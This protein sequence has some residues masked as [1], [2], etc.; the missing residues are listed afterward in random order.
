MKGVRKNTEKKQTQRAADSDVHHGL[1]DALTCYMLADVGRNAEEVWIQSVDEEWIKAL[2][3]SSHYLKT[4]KLD[5]YDRRN[6]FPDASLIAPDHPVHLFVS[7]K[8]VLQVYNMVWKDSN[9]RQ[10]FQSRICEGENDVEKVRKNAQKMS[11]Q[12]IGEVCIMQRKAELMGAGYAILACF[13]E[14]MYFLKKLLEK[15]ELHGKYGGCRCM[16][17]KRA[18][19]RSS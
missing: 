9:V 16:R 8:Q 13:A 7:R 6:R 14:P 5:K 17:L 19:I 4:V 1:E 15:A 11:Y 10:M 12:S 2:W 18:Y 3:F